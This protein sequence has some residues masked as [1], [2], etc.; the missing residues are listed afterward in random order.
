MGRLIEAIRRANERDRKFIMSLNLSLLEK[1]LL[2]LFV[3][4]L[5]LEFLD[6]YSTML[7]IRNSLIFHELNPIASDLFSMRFGGFMLAMVFK[8]LPGV[9][10]FYAVFVQDP[11]NKHPFGLRMA[12]FVALVSLVSI[13]GVLFYIVGWNNLPTLFTYLN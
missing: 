9:P 5:C 11:S 2:P 3:A 7:A 13:D 6:V 1:I 4:Y 12:R 8:Y 10:L